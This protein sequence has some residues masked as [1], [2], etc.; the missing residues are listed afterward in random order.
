MSDHDPKPVRIDLMR[1]APAAGGRAEWRS[2]EELTGSDAFRDALERE[3][4]RQASEWDDPE[5][6]RNFMKVMG[7]SIALAGL[8]GCTRQP[9]EKIVP[10]VKPPDQLVPGRPLYFAT[11]VNDEGYAR[12]VLVKSR[13]GRPIKLEGNPDHPASGGATDAATQAAIL[14][15]YD[16]DR[17]Q[18][19]TY[20]GEIRPWGSFLAAMKSAIEAQRPLGGAGVRI[21]TGTLTSPTLGRQLK[22]LLTDLPAA[23]WHQWEPAGGGFNRAASASTEE[24]RYHFDRADVV[25]SLD[26]DF[27]GRGPGNLAL[28]RAFSERRRAPVVAAPAAEGGHGPEPAHEAEPLA[29]AAAEAPPM[30]RLYAIES[31]PTLTG[32]QADHR[33]VVRASEVEGVA[34]QLAAELGAAS[35]APTTAVTTRAAWL[36][37]LAH[38]LQTQRGRCLVMAGDTQPPAVHE[39]ARAMNQA[40]G[41]VGSAVEYVPSVEVLPVDPIASLRELVTDIDAGRVALL[42]IAGSNPV[43]TAPVDF[44]FAA[45]L[46]K[47]AL[48]VHLG[49]Y[50]DETAERC[51]W[52]LPEAHSLEAWS[53]ARAFDGTLTIQQ[54]LIAP[55]YGGKSL[56]ELLAAFTAR[57]ER[58]G[59][60]IVREH[61]SA[62]VG[63]DFEHWWRKALHDGVAVEP[64]GEPAFAAPAAAPPAAAAS[65]GPDTKLELIFRPDPHVHDGR[66]AN[67]GWLQEMPRPLTKVTWENVALMSPA[68]AESLGVSVRFTA[69][70][71]LV[72]EVELRYRG[73]SVRGPAWILPGHPE[74]SVTVTLGHGRTRAGRVGTG[75][76]FDAYRLRTCDAPWFGQGLEVVKTGVTAMVAVTQEHWLMEGRHLVRSVSVTEYGQN[77]AAYL[78]G[79]AEVVMA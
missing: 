42:V 29:A 25:V 78:K 53:D 37:A 13:E 22:E 38:D 3:F 79:T 54:P 46:E 71:T 28:V 18:T 59:Y 6:R 62:R 65:R 32:A 34:R 55:L 9:E 76:G 58:S 69:R 20:L 5:G 11:A 70:G 56:H 31:S 50:D 39:L 74:S 60:E 47:V 52:H 51:H 67:N 16:P 26:A 12:G 2:L 40:L 61:W 63:G 75:V 45:K 64:P 72:D 35:G 49:L 41:A 15:L 33:L 14:G 57:P 66:F 44:D 68:L 17:S 4:P 10:Y 1:R 27:I 48:R 77:L 8:T 24:P 21:L 7:A 23:R 19:L 73:R 30:I 36:A 43:Y